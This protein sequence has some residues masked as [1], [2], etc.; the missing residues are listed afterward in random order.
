MNSSTS[1]KELKM[2]KVQYKSILSG[3]WVDSYLGNFS[4]V[5]RAENAAKKEFANRY[6]F[7]VIP[8]NNSML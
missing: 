6:E 2:F 7:R 8:S 3:E 1:R 5:K 4:T